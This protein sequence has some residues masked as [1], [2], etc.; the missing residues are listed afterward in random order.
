[1]ALRKKKKKKKK[2]ALKSFDLDLR[3]DEWML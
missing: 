2:S 3:G 1:M